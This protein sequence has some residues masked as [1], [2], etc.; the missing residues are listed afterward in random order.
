MHVKAKSKGPSN[1][2]I[3]GCCLIHRDRK[4]KRSGMVQ[5][6]KQDPNNHTFNGGMV[7]RVR[8][9]ACTNNNLTK[10]ELH[11]DDHQPSNQRSTATDSTGNE[12]PSKV[13]NK[14]KEKHTQGK[15]SEK[16]K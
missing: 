15:I 16:F 14:H 11:D 1:L 2:V 3:Y 8:V 4:K 12:Q 6:T 5:P 13:E 9:R 10:R 7:D